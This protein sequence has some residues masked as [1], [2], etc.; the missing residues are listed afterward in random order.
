MRNKIK[1]I[2]F[3]TINLVDT[4]ISCMAILIFSSFT[5]ATRFKKS[6]SNRKE[7]DRCSVMGNGPS[8]DDFL[9][10]DRT[11]YA[12]KNLIAVN[13]FCNSHKFQ[14]IKPNFYVISDPSVFNDDLEINHLA[15]KIILL[16]TNMSKVNWNIILFVPF[17]FRKTEFVKKIRS[18]FVEVNFYNDTP[19][20]GFKKIMHFIYKNNLGMPISESVIIS[21]IFIA[22]NLKF[23][24]IQLF[25][26]DQSWLKDVRVD[27]D[28]SVSIGFDHFNGEVNRVKV[29]TD[30]TDFLLSQ[31]RLFNSHRLLKYYSEVRNIKI[32]N[33]TKDSFIDSYDK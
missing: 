19:V 28:N 10:N 9:K 32:I 8:L 12:R 13:F 31:A 23:S 18:E 7:S 30:L 15:D 25:G 33:M 22:I 29:N 1:S 26:V 2:Y 21:A 3:F 11:T 6:F 14:I 20:K 24:E 5:V 27:K 4:I 16:L 17:R